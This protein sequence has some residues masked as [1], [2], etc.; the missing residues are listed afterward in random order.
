MANAGA[1]RVRVVPW[2]NFFLNFLD[3]LEKLAN[4]SPAGNPGSA[5]AD[6]Y[7]ARSNGA[8]T[9]KGPLP[10]SVSPTSR[11]RDRPEGTTAGQSHPGPS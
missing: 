7:E 10:V 9:C 6:T 3:F 4:Y 1:R 5:T 11:A 8:G 2:I